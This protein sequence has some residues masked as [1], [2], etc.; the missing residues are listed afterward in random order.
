MLV[1][2]FVSIQSK[3]G[4]YF[5]C[6]HL[7]VASRLFWSHKTN[8]GFSF[9][10]YSFSHCHA[11]ISSPRDSNSPIWGASWLPL[12][13]EYLLSC[14]VISAEHASL[15]SLPPVRIPRCLRG[16]TRLPAG[17]CLRLGQPLQDCHQSGTNT[18]LELW[19]G[20]SVSVGSIKYNFKLQ[21][22]TRQR[23]RVSIS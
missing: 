15:S 22:Y 23:S 4:L 18:E 16:G 6:L 13:V 12:M 19:R 9:L 1:H 17:F 20:H 11:I 10:F 7:V 14:C 2:T 21:S 5:S 3:T 8:A